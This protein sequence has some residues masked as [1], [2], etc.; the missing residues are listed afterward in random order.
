MILD[1]YIFGSLIPRH[2][3]EGCFLESNT[4]FK[5]S[6]VKDPKSLV[7]FENPGLKG[8]LDFIIAKYI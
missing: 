1:A 8:Y 7:T 4:P 6:Q 3:E 5:A 2:F